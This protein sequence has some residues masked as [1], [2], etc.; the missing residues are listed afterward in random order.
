M[1]E[2][3][4]LVAPCFFGTESTLAFEVRRL[5][6]GNVQVTD[7][8]VTFQGGAELIAAANLNLRTAERVLLL[9]ATAR[10]STFDELFDAVYA[11]PWE[12]LLP[13]D[14][15]FPVKGSS[16]SSQLSSVPACQ[17]IVK[18]AVVKRLMAGH[19]VSTLPETGALYK[20]RFALRK[21]RME[22]YLDTSGD[23]LHKRGYRR[24][25]MEAPLRETLAAT[26]ADLGRVRRDS[27]VEDPFCGSGT[28]VIEAAQKA[29][30]MAPGLQRRFA[31]ERY[32]FVPPEVWAAQR[33]KAL[34]E[35]RQD[36]AFEGFGYDI[37]PAAVELARANARLA[38]VDKRCHFEVADV[39]DFVPRSEAIVLTNPPYGE[40]MS[41]IDGAARLARTFGRQMEAHPCAG[42]YVI[43]ADMEF[44][45][46]Y[47]RRAAKR[48]KMYNGMIPCQVYMYYDA[49]SAGKAKPMPALSPDGFDGRRG[50]SRPKNASR[51]GEKTSRSDK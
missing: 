15:A 46:H 48:R 36:A 44:E 17:S 18:K 27:V 30:N 38:G 28:L 35:I 16:L 21:D 5:G 2:P 39:K 20:L 29:L 23:G 19:H 6:A 33:Q 10:T 8:R 40:R 13:P 42:V 43:T 31:A 26:I 34:A 4:T 9:L 50:H 14:A 24:N 3:Y 11:I 45:A 51:P 32:S 25:A 7:G 1:P 12:E 49:P 22:M 41:T 47:G 37:D